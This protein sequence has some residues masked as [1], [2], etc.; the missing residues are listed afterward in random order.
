MFLF[1]DG[2]FDGD[3]KT[4][5]R[6]ILEN[7]YTYLKL[8][9]VFLRKYAYA[10]AVAPQCPVYNELMTVNNLIYNAL[11]YAPSK[12]LITN[13][14]LVTAMQQISFINPLELYEINAT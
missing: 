12:H 1:N 7:L 5:F 8:Y 6:L 13:N 2:S 10:L 11:S 4:A 14:G 3:N 9:Y